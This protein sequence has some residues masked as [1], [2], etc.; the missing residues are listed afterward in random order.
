MID[1]IKFLFAITIVR[2]HTGVPLFRVVSR[3]GVPF[4]VIVSA[5]LFF[6]NENLQFKC[7]TIKKE[8]H[9]GLTRLNDQIKSF[10]ISFTMSYN[11]LTIKER[12]M[13]L[14]LQAKGLTIWGIALRMKCSPS[15]ITSELKR[16][17]MF[18]HPVKM[19]VTIIVND[20]AVISHDC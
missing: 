16:C 11:H 6:S 17:T 1:L 5:F 13:L 18:I 19:S 2:I 4:F 10:E 12:E 9:S 15:T 7:N 20:N 8:N 14:Y 3:I